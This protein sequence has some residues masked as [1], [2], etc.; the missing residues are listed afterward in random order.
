M[1]SVFPME[2]VVPS[3]YSLTSAN[4]PTMRAS[5]I[6]TYPDGSARVMVIAGQQTWAAS[7]SSKTINLRTAAVS[8]NPLTTATIAARFT[9]G[10]TVNFGGGDQPLNMWT[11]PHRVWWANSQ[12][13]CARYILSC[14]KGLME[15]HIDVHAFA[16]GHTFVEFVIENSKIN[17]GLATPPT[18]PGPSRETYT[19]ATIAIN[20]TTVATVSPPVQ[21]TY[22]GAS[23]YTTGTHEKF[24]AFYVGAW[25]NTSNVATPIRG[26]S[27]PFIEMSHDLTHMQAHPIWPGKNARAKTHNPLVSYGRD[28]P[29]VRSSVGSIAQAY[30]ED[31]YQPW[32]IGRFKAANMANPG[33]ISQLPWQDWRYVQGP[34]RYTR[35]AVIASTL[36][37][38][39]YYI[40]YRDSTGD[41]PSFTRIGS[42]FRNTFGYLPVESGVQPDYSFYHQ[43]GNG[44]M[45]F[46]CQP[47]PC[48]IE[49]MQKKC[50]WDG[51][52]A[53]SVPIHSQ[54]GYGGTRSLAFYVRHLNQAVFATPDGHPWKASGEAA[55]YS[56]LQHIDGWRT[57]GGC[58]LN[59]LSYGTPTQQADQRPTTTDP[60]YEASMWQVVWL[61]AEIHKAVNA[62]VL[63]N[64]TQLAAV[65][66]LRDWMLLAPVRMVN[67]QS[68][69]G[70]W[71]YQCSYQIIG[72]RGA[73]L[74]NR[75]G[76]DGSGFSYWSGTDHGG[77]VTWDAMAQDYYP[78][79]PPSTVNG[80]WMVNFDTGRA[81]APE[82]PIPKTGYA[83][84]NATSAANHASE[85]D[86]CTALWPWYCMAVEADVPGATTMWSTITNGGIT[87]LTTWLN[88]FGTDLEDGIWPRNLPVNK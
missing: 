59:V 1:A 15:A 9:S 81:S 88:G 45:G 25:L 24:R 12:V 53:S 77:Y 47:S 27:D 8:D 17:C 67:E 28:H 71:R 82:D 48:F 37:Y 5:V 73:W 46:L 60:F 34:D 6:S 21:G 11:S 22:G 23:Y 49:L 57:G 76:T 29:Y 87:N 83:S 62:K 65:R 36:G 2:G 32:D 84:Y 52:L 85:Y 51:T 19:N 70:G 63:S 4:D 44:L 3:G 66:T 43:F 33:W 38:L 74:G 10:I 20:G 69:T 64:P 30:S 56:Q 78:D 54:D 58:K 39:S 35:R 55:L 41:V 42:K 40:N 18:L 79:Y 14:G 7:N 86:Y 31:L 72:S 50:V 13:I 61:A 68:H 16:T 26:S 75:D 80:P